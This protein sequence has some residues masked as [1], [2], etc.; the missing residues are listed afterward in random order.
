[1]VPNYWNASTLTVLICVHP[2]P[3]KTFPMDPR[4][5]PTIEMEFSSL[6]TAHLIFFSSYLKEELIRLNLKYIR[7]TLYQIVMKAEIDCRLSEM[8]MGKI[9]AESSQT[10]PRSF[11][12]ASM[13]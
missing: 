6:L 10:S 2:Q 4:W 1:M 5:F 13:H 7:H 11:L 8:S 12:Q 3:L 9:F